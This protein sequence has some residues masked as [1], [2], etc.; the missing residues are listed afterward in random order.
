MGLRRGYPAWLAAER[1]GPAVTGGLRQVL[2]SEW[3][4]GNVELRWTVGDQQAQYVR[5]DL[6]MAFPMDADAIAAEFAFPRDYVVSDTYVG[7]RR[8]TVALAASARGSG[9]QLTQ[10]RLHEAWW[11]D[12][13]SAPRPRGPGRLRRRTVGAHESTWRLL[14]R[15]VWLLARPGTDGPS[16]F[17]EPGQDGA[18]VTARFGLP[19]PGERLPAYH[20]WRVAV[21]RDVVRLLP[22]G[23]GI[24]LEPGTQSQRRFLAPDVAEMAGHAVAFPPSADIA[25]S[26]PRPAWLARLETRGALDKL[27]SEEALTRLWVAGYRV[28]D[29]DEQVVF[30]YEATGL[31][32]KAERR[33]ADAA[34][35]AASELR[36]C[37]R[38][39]AASLGVVPEA[40]QA[41]LAAQ[42]P[43]IG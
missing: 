28:E 17:P 39:S 24:L 33:L 8:G 26:T 1:R 34:Y 27:G 32:E 15:E 31:D 2:E 3:L 18:Y 40:G 19:R 14:D 6:G 22:A 42:Q 29:A 30:V 10:Q 21:L 13:R 4:R 23:T 9:Y 38:V 11:D 20:H 43:V 25:W 41:W 37:Y 36:R 12:W 5:N 16:F 35:R 7:Q